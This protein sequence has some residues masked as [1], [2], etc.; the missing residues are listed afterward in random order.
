MI[1]ISCERKVALL[2]P[3]QLHIDTWDIP[4]PWKPVLQPRKVFFSEGETSLN[5]TVF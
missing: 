1:H 3:A 5:P 4:G 2:L